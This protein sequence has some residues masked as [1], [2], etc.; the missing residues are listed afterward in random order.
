MSGTE[1][2]ALVVAVASTLALCLLI[3]VLVWLLRTLRALGAAVEELRSETLATVIEMRS[4]VRGAQGDLDRADGLLDA[5][6]R[7]AAAAE[8]TSRVTNEAL[9]T[10]MIKAM[11]LAAGTSQAARRLRGRH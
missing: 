4:A 1:V 3:A 8:S 10:P 5:A 11:A 9:S 6:E 7:V 2:T